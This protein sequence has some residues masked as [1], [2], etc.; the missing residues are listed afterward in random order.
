[1][2]RGMSG[3]PTWKQRLEGRMDAPLAEEIDAFATQMVLRK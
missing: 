2:V 3:H 1:M